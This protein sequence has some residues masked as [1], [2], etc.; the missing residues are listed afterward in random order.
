MKNIGDTGIKQEVIE[1]IYG[2]AERY[3]VK[4]VILFSSNLAERF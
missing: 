4:R 3:G 1:E 2:L